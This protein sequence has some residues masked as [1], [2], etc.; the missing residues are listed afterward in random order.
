MKTKLILTIL[1]TFCL[2]SNAFAFYDLDALDKKPVKKAEPVKVVQ[3]VKQVKKPVATIVAT[4]EPVVVKPAQAKVNK[5]VVKKAEPV[6]T[7][8]PEVA[9]MVKKIKA[10]HYKK[11]VV[12]AKPV[13]TVKVHKTVKRHYK[14]HYKKAVKR[15]THRRRYV[16]KASLRKIE[17]IRQE[18]ARL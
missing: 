3:P 14:K 6:Y 16:S 13:Q 17:K 10:E 4:P 2:S 1:V 7:P 11:A 12:K 5:P 18:L 8:T 15:V 9:A